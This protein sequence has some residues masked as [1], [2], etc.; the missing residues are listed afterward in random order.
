MFCLREEVGCY[1]YW[2]CGLVG[3]YLGVSLFHSESLMSGDG[4]AECVRRDINEVKMTRT[5]TSDGPA[6]MSIATKA[7]VSF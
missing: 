3:D 4:K 5:N 6:G 1:E 7:S 2:V